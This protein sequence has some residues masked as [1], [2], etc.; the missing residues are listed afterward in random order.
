MQHL[1]R[2]SCI[3]YVVF[4]PV[5]IGVGAS[6]LAASDVFS[7]LYAILGI[8]QLRLV[9]QAWS[10]FHWMLLMLFIVST[11]HVAI[12][13]GALSSYVVLNKDIG[14][15]VL[16]VSY[17][18]LTTSATT[19]DDVE[20]MLQV[21]VIATTL[22]AAASVA[23]L[24]LIK[25]LGNY[26]LSALVYLGGRAAGFLV[27]PNAFGGLLLVSLSI[28]T[29]TFFSG[30]PLVKGLLGLLCILVLGM[31]LVLTLSRSAW[32]GFA[33]A[34]ILAVFLRPKI[35]V[36]YVTAGLMAALLLFAVLGGDQFES[37]MG[38]ANRPNTAQQRL[39]Q[40]NQAVP[41][42]AL[43]PI[44]GTGLGVFIQ[45][46]GS[47]IH[48]TTVWITT[49]F[50]LVGL[51]VFWGLI[52]WYFRRAFLAFRVAD[53]SRRPIILGLTCAHAGMVGLSFGIEALYQRHWW[54]VMAMIASCYGLVVKPPLQSGALLRPDG[55]RGGLED[56]G[57]RSMMPFSY[58]YVRSKVISE[59]ESDPA[60][61]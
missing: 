61:K 46:N 5:Q 18:M 34:A 37:I 11:V 27:D 21:F 47:I 24:L 52:L 23:G 12:L 29:V 35:A 19:W 25:V 22:H 54:F 57:S 4:L 45:K 8:A 48:N 49:D 31:G 43:N 42:I 36:A 14:L 20:T 38:I 28:Q 60:S 1:L 9:R 32:I 30:R 17:A 51:I 58:P 6:R 10:I 15:G 44:L 53:D 26:S 33:I 2:L 55:V 7:A 16:F 50:G 39:T 41:M 59:T 40:I 13:Q 3:A 56:V